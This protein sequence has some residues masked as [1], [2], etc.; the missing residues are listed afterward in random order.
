MLSLPKLST[1]V[2]VGQKRKFEQWSTSTRLTSSGIFLLNDRKPASTWATGI[3]SLA[4]ARTPARV[5]LVSPKTKA[6]SGLSF[7]KYFLNAFQHISSLLAM[8]SGSNAQM[9]IGIWYAQFLEEDPA[10]LV[11]VMLTGVNDNLIHILANFSRD[12]CELD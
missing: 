8:G 2:F 7:K 4:A 1:A 10:H 9:I 11:I 5:V 12:W 6:I 3:C